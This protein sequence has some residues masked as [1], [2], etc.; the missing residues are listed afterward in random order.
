MV[1]RRLKIKFW[2]S[3]ARKIRIDAEFNEI[4]EVS[5]FPPRLPDASIIKKGIGNNNFQLVLI[6]TNFI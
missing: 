1:P 4:F 3:R 5:P 2:V 6:K